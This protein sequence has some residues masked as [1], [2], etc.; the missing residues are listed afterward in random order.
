MVGLQQRLLPVLSVRF[1][2]TDKRIQWLPR[3]KPR[4]PH[5]EDA[6]ALIAKYV[7]NDDLASAAGAE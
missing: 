1:E 6:L 5:S 3:T 4:Y 2:R 7:T